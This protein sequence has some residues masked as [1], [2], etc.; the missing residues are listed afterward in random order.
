V[1][2]DF[3]NT[4]DGLSAAS[5]VLGINAS[6][7]LLANTFFHIWDLGYGIILAAVSTPLGLALGIIANKDKFKPLKYPT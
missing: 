6:L 2:D 5:L 1:T 7:Y 4:G 3:Y